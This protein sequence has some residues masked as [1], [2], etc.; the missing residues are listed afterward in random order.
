MAI[1]EVPLYKVAYSDL[2][3]S[4]ALFLEQLFAANVDLYDVSTSHF[5]FK[6]LCANRKSNRGKGKKEEA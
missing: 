5:Q 3:V 6:I 1:K 2:A 4:I